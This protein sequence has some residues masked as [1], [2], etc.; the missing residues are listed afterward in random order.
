MQFKGIS[1]FCN[2]KLIQIELPDKKSIVLDGKNGD[3]ILSLIRSILSMDYNDY[4]LDYGDMKDMLLENSYLRF[5]NGGIACRDNA[6]TIDGSVPKIHCV[7]ARKNGGINSFLISNNT[8]LTTISFNMTE[9]TDIIDTNSWVRLQ[10]LINRFAGFEF[11]KIDSKKLY[12]NSITE[13]LKLAYLL[14][15]ESFLTPENYL[16]IVLI[17]KLGVFSPSRFCEFMELLDN[18]HRLEVILTT[19]DINIRSNSVITLVDC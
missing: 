17:P 6:I 1:A 13:E 10:E 9:Y 7:Y 5:T 4:F 8:D 18:I 14:M 15:A 3:F 19:E 11:L 12:F 16:R 2:G